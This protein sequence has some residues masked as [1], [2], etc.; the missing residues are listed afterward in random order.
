MPS[1][2]SGSAVCSFDAAR[3]FALDSGAMLVVTVSTPEDAAAP[4]IAEGIVA[5]LFII[6]GSCSPPPS[7]LTTVIGST[8]C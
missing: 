3:F 8:T 1:N 2:D 4:P 6:D 5:D 7:P